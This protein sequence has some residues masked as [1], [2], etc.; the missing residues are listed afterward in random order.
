MIDSFEERDKRHEKCVSPR[1]NIHVGERIAADRRAKSAALVF[2]H[3][4]KAGVTL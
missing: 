1:A 2:F 3:C 4:E